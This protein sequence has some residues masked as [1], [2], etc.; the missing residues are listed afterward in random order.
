MLIITNFSTHARGYLMGE[1]KMRWKQK[2]WCKI[3]IKM[4]DLTPWLFSLF[5]F[6][7]PVDMLMSRQ[8]GVQF[9]AAQIQHLLFSRRDMPTARLCICP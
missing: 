3:L 9:L 2:C 1:L 4:G 7:W 8:Q 6:G 5:L